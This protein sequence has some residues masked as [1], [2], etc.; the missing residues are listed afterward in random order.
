MDDPAS[1]GQRRPLK[2][3]YDGT[4]LA[5]RRGFG[6]FARGMLTGLAETNPGHEIHV[7]ID[8]P[9]SDAVELPNGVIRR[10]VPLKRSPSQ[11][12]NARG[13]RSLGEIWTI[14]RAV[15]RMQFDLYY[16]PSSFTYFPLF[17]GQK[18]IVT[19]HDTLAVER[20]DLVFPT[21][22]GR[23]FWWLK[24]QA[25]RWNTSRLTTVSA[26][27][28]RDLARFFRVNESA[29]GLL[30]EGVEEVFLKPARALPDRQSTLQ[31][32]S[33]PT[34]SNYWLYVGGLSPHKNL[35]RLIDA[36][37]RLPESVGNL[38][39]VG[40]FGDTFH[41]HVPELRAKSVEAGVAER[42]IF[43]G[44]VPDDELATLYRNSRAVILPSL[45]EGFGLPAAEAMACG[46]ALLHSHAGSLPEV[47]GDAGLVFDPLD[48][49]EMAAQWLKI[50]TDDELRDELARRGLERSGH[51][52]WTTAGRLLWNEISAVLELNDAQ[53][54][55]A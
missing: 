16:L 34:S 7:V 25:A 10:V 44:F 13:S 28:R 24:E 22:Q 40:D 4:C 30:T 46:T 48:V 6:R 33:I 15:S 20:P 19:M 35:L 55:S 41:T 27:S 23:W 14:A 2:I 47:A 43:T 18:S 42:V 52:R 50:A 53:S 36:F 12:A 51:F 5:N 3:G 11:A 37:S 21:I 54:R 38:V 39:L 8:E 17:P 29:I 1:A 45:W 9:S 49:A 26:T 32:Y 31:K